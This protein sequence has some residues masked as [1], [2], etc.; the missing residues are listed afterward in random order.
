MNI[1][2]TLQPGRQKGDDHPVDP[3]RGVPPPPIFLDF[4]EFKIAV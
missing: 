3:K 2:W 4:Q 1:A